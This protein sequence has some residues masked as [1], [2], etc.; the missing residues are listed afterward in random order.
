MIL[1]G[2]WVIMKVF[3]GLLSFALCAN[4]VAEP[5]PAVS[6]EP[7]GGISFAR[8]EIPL[9][10]D[11]KTGAIRGVRGCAD[12]WRSGCFGLWQLTFR[13]G[14]RRVR[15]SEGLVGEAEGRRRS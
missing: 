4:L 8:T 5:L 12:G 11:P 3:L 10:L 2:R 1:Q 6:V 13:G 9:D 7:A 14:G 15:R